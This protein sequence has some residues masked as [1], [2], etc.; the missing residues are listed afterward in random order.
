ML[1]RPVSLIICVAMVMMAT[2]PGLGGSASRHA[3]RPMAS[4]LSSS[5]KQSSAG[6]RIVLAGLSAALVL[7][8]SGGKA[9]ADPAQVA[10][11]ASLPPPQFPIELNPIPPAP[12]EPIISYAA[13]VVASARLNAG[14]FKNYAQEYSRVEKMAKL[15]IPDADAEQLRRWR[16][17]ML[18]TVARETNFLDKYNKK[19]HNGNG[20]YQITGHTAY[21]IVHNYMTWPVANKKGKIVAT[22]RHREIKR[23]KRLLKLL[24]GGRVTWD[25]VW[26][27]NRE[28]LR[29]LC[30]TDR[31]FACFISFYVYREKF[32]RSGVWK[33]PPD[34]ALG[35]IWK[36]YY[37]TY[38]GKGTEKG[39]NKWFDIIHPPLSGA[40]TILN[41]NIWGDC[42]RRYKEKYPQ[43]ETE[44][45]KPEKSFREFAVEDGIFKHL[46]HNAAKLLEGEYGLIS[47]NADWELFGPDRI[48]GVENRWYFT[49]KQDAKVHFVVVRREKGYSAYIYV[50]DD[51]AAATKGKE[52][53]KVNIFAPVEM[54]L[55]ICKLFLVRQEE[56]KDNRE[57]TEPVKFSSS[58]GAVPL[59]G[60]TRRIDGHILSQA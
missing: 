26:K 54:N 42:S 24:T 30:V 40:L 22:G 44:G 41:D 27:M 55:K 18:G 38:K 15:I 5:E 46:A 4:S 6:K 57:L 49:L 60:S 16:L 36:K 8:L 11:L 56:Q 20:F 58:G 10:L 48:H 2:T 31:D 50:C 19:S 53:A 14:Q 51:I 9:Q 35:F 52:V 3:L 34:Y 12:E 28:Q 21:G 37:N 25:K 47:E 23:F 17:L 39:F 29:G 32:E 33:L 7:G 43:P 13:A 59:A 1:K 45:V